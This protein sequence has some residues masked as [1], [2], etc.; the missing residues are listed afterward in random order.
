M[1]NF[2]SDFIDNRMGRAILAQLYQRIYRI[3]GTNKKSFDITIK[4]ISDPAHNPKPVGSFFD[5]D[6]EKHAL[7]LAV[8]TNFNCFG[9]RQNLSLPN[10]V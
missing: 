1:R 6:A 3:L 7:N 10:V 5:P 2:H 8:D 9:L 4:A